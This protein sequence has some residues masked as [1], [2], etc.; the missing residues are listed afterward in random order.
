MISRIR[1]EATGET[2]Q[3]RPPARSAP[4]G[5][6]APK[7]RARP[8]AVMAIMVGKR[9][10]LP[11]RLHSAGARRSGPWRGPPAAAQVGGSQA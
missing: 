4:G 5:T 8:P 7:L 2:P 1:A 11:L 9:A 3:A 10:D 6:G